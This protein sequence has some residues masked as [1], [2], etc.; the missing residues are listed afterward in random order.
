MV[1]ESMAAKMQVYHE[2]AWI[3]IIVTTL[4]PFPTIM[5]LG[6][7]GLKTLHASLYAAKQARFR[8]GQCV[9]ALHTEP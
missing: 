1:E 8:H 9:A 2:H 3:T 7:Y 4:Q 5:A 6:S